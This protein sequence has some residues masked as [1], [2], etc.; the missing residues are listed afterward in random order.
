MSH[1]ITVELPD[2]VYNAVQQV[3]TA[4]GNTPAEW[5]AVQIPSLLSRG[6]EK[7]LRL[8]IPDEGVDDLLSSLNDGG[9]E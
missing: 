5:I 7:A 8:E 6:D 1:V 4:T 9:V 3:A 2:S